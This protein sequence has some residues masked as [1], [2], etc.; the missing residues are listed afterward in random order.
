MRVERANAKINLYLDVVSR[1]EDGYHNLISLMQ[2][3]SLCDVVTVEYRPSLHTSIYLQASGNDEMP[4][5]CR[6]LAWR[7]AEVF[8]SATGR[9]GEVRITIE[10]HIPMAAGLAG[11]SADAAAVLRGLNHLC[12]APFSRRRLCELGEALGADVPFCVVG[13]S[14]MVTGIGECLEEIAPLPQ[15]HMV[16]ACMGEGVSTPRAYGK[17]DEKY[18]FFSEAPEREPRVKEIE[19]RLKAKKL[20]EASEFFYN[21]F[22]EVVPMEQP[23]VD[24]LK[25]C[26]I[27][28]DAVCAMMSGSGPS[29]FGIFETAEAAGD[30]YSAL[31]EMG[32]TAF[33]CHPTPAYVRDENE[34]TH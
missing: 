5:D 21:V 4:L 17:L 31:R 10:K 27:Q 20:F 11:G 19:K 26:M 1:R 29:V 13:G 8:L 23:W 22:E 16:V 34:K 7:A 18:G 32:V 3:V 14:A 25:N 30:A 2:T 12:G 15:C 6:N 9:S 28:N 24:R 33:V